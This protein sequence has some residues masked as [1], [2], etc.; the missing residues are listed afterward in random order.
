[1][2]KV[3]SAPDWIGEIIYIVLVVVSFGLLTWFWTSLWIPSQF[4][5]WFVRR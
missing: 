3:G 1:M 4:P 5:F 2:R